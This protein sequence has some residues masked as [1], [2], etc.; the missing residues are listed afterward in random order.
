M[1]PVSGKRFEWSE[2]HH[3]CENSDY[4]ATQLGHLY[5]YIKNNHH[6]GNN[7]FGD[8]FLANPDKDIVYEIKH[9]SCENSDYK[10]TQLS[11]L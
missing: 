5:N 7:S 3:S 6:P 2:K 11:H 4:K 1:H 8:I 10:A 9:N